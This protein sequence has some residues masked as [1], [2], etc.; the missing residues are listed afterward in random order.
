MVQPRGVC[1]SVVVCV[2]VCAQCLCVCVCVPDPPF[3]EMLCGLSASCLA[4]C[5]HCRRSRRQIDD[6]NND[7][8]NT[9]FAK[10]STSSLVCDHVLAV[11]SAHSGIEGGKP[12]GKTALQLLRAQI[13]ARRSTV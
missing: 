8:G 12:Q 5:S 7:D 11:V 4:Y 3:L 10:L 2:C 1:V 13:N 9:E 6:D